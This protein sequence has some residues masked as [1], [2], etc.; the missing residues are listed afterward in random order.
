MADETEV[1]NVPADSGAE[2]AASQA[3][4]EQRADPSIDVEALASEFGWTPVEG[5]RGN[6]DDWVPAGEFLK[7]AAKLHK[8][9]R[10]DVK[11][12]RRTA[13]RLER[14]AGQIAQEK[15]ER[16]RSEWERAHV[17]AV[18]NGDPAAARKAAAE[19]DRIE[20]QSTE[21]VAG[22]DPERMFAAAN[23]WYGKDEDAT[24]L[25]QGVSMRLAQQGRTIDEQLEAA[26]A[27]VRKRFPELF[28]ETAPKRRAPAVH[29]A[30][31]RSVP[32]SK[33]K[34]AANLPPSARNAG[35]DFVRRGMVDSLEEYAKTW[36][37]E[38]GQ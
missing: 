16:L 32:P 8:R 12:L 10:E 22:D 15:F 36:F 29:D 21:Q 13:E 38:N 26:Q 35:L 3:E 28:G 34:G 19:L 31:T 30:A 1:T 9:T 25:A 6:P 4:A 5:W 2:L 33:E 37:Q 23:P 14:T 20:R 11:E 18:E 24:A 17:E 27:A 7:S